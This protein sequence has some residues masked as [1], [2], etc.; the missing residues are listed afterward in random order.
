M[1]VHTRCLVE[2][3][4]R[5]G[6]P[7]SFVDGDDNF[8]EINLGGKRYYFPGASTPFNDGAT[9][10]ICRDKEFSYKLLKGVIAMPKS[11]GFVDPEAPEKYRDWARMATTEAI[12]E[13][14]CSEFALPVIVKRNSGSQGRHVFLCK[15]RAEVATAVRK[16]FEKDEDGTKDYDHVLLAQE[17]IVAKKEYRAVVFGGN[18]LML[19]EKDVS[20]A[21]FTGNLSPLHW[22]NSKAVQVA[23]EKT[24]KRI[25]AFTAP[26]YSLLDLRYGGLDII[27][28]ADGKLNLVELNSRPGFGLF[29]KDNGSEPLI[30][31]YVKILQALG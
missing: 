31:M 1:S 28:D 12:V 20:D 30:Q 13:K 26:I 17:Y 23:D 22:E 9:S 11:L 29:A 21:V 14:I 5:L 27:E 18:I 7:H 10:K 24:I 19:Y 2:A 3:C 6:V 4:E 16:V 8:L 15:D 25:Q